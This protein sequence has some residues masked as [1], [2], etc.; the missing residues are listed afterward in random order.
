MISL[1]TSVL[2]D[3]SKKEQQYA[4]A[5]IDTYPELQKALLINY[6]EMNIDINVNF[7]NNDF[8]LDYVQCDS[9]HDAPLGLFFV[10]RNDHID[11]FTHDETGEVHQECSYELPEGFDI[12]INIEKFSQLLE[13]SKKEDHPD[14]VNADIY[15]LYSTLPHEILHAIAFA[16]DSNQKTPLE[17]YDTNNDINSIVEIQ[18]KT[19]LRFE[20]IGTTE[21]DFCEDMGE[22]ITDIVV[23]QT[24][25]LEEVSQILYQ[26]KET[27]NTLKFISK[28][29]E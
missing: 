14:N 1:N 19:T 25:F 22:N 3:F 13:V 24:N 2:S 9:H 29:F 4:Q 7:V 23:P 12:F 26:K 15:S 17:I 10:S 27:N 28:M 5:F 16:Q 8:M 6:K 11:F 18:K 20:S 21:E